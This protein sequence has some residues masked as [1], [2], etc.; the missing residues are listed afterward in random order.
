MG[1]VGVAALRLLQVDESHGHG[2]L[3]PNHVGRLA[4]AAVIQSLGLPQVFSLVFHIRLVDVDEALALQPGIESLLD[5]QFDVVMRLHDARLGH[6]LQ[7]LGLGH[8]LA[9]LAGVEHQLAT[10]QRTLQP[11]L[12]KEAGTE[13]TGGAA[14]T[15]E[16]D[17]IDGRSIRGR[18]R[19]GAG[20][21]AAPAWRVRPAADCRLPCATLSDG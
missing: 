1:G 17:R 8:G 12:G 9:A 2:I 20:C 10:A 7:S 6:P 16:R 5:L 15:V 3:G 21:S 14:P 13:R 4:D 18:Q 19:D 11:G